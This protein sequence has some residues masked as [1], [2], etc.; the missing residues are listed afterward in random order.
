[1]SRAERIPV[2]LV[3]G[4]LGS[5]KTTLLARW[6]R[7]PALADAAVVVNELGEVGLDDRLLAAGADSGVAAALLA[8]GCVCCTGL[9]GLEQALA[10]LF[11]DRLHRRRPR[12]A[13]VVVETTGLA[14][15]RPVVEALAR[16]PLLA[17]RYRLAGVVAT[18][19]ATSGV[20]A[21]ATHAEARAQVD[22]SD[23]VV[24]TKADLADPGPVLAALRRRGVGA[25]LATSARASL[26]WA[27]AEAAMAARRSAP[28]PALEVA[29]APGGREST[30]AHEHEHAHTAQ[31][32]FLP[33]PDALP[34]AALHAHL[35]H[36]L[37]PPPWRLKG[38]ARLNDG[39]WVSVQWSAG[40]AQA[41]IEP[42]AGTPPAAGLTR[43]AAAPA[44][45]A[46]HRAR[47]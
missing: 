7:A 32:D 47:G 11:W 39:R 2:W 14:D 36:A 16:E 23:L 37:Q 5:G 35:A 29:R 31:A 33:L 40:D 8:G 22:A 9:P 1:M 30:R 4:W 13:S 17:E 46:S 21:L 19:A 20:E 10:D 15:P 26:G 25:A 24:V 6:L 44:P 45:R 42:L 18:L 34:L 3:T 41:S 12:F 38:A 43:I 27:Q 28:A